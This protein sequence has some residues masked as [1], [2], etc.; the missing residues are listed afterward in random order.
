MACYFFHVVRDV[1]VF[2]D[3]DGQD[4]SSVDEA[5]AHAVRIAKELAEEGEDYRLFAVCVVDE[6]SNGVALVPIGQDPQ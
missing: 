3:E 6:Q 4:F 2:S 1:Q 5:R